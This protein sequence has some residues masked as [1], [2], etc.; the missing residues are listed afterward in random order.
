MEEERFALTDLSDRLQGPAGAEAVDQTLQRL[1][2]LQAE[3]KQ[4]AEEGVPPD[5]YD[6]LG[7]CMRSRPA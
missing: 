5:I 2:T 1:R 3:V 7:R 4:R 6:R